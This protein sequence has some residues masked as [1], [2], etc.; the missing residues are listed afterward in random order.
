[1]DY[2]GLSST[3]VEPCGPLRLLWT[4]LDYCGL[5]RTFVDSLWFLWTLF[6]SCELLRTLMDPRW[7]LVD[8]C[9]LSS[10]LVDPC[11]LRI[12]L[13][14]LA[15]SKTNVCLV[16]PF[17]WP[18]RPVSKGLMDYISSQVL[19]P[20][21][22]YLSVS[23]FESLFLC[24]LKVEFLVFSFMALLANSSQVIYDFIIRN[25]VGSQSFGAVSWLLM[26][27][28]AEPA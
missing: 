7:T 17:E 16:I 13:L 25:L 20:D 14:F 3:L 28:T 2:F 5:L 9:G 19:L 10:T 23:L 12:Y 15:A 11:G 21:L 1:M 18:D 6:D 24:S 27:N 4:I 8:F 22:L 26:K